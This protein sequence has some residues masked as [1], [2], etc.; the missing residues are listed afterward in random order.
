MHLVAGEGPRT[1]YLV[2]TTQEERSGRPP[3]VLQFRAAEHAV[4][5]TI[6]EFLPK[7]AV[8]LSQTVRLTTKSVQG[9]LGLISIQ[10]GE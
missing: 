3:R 2:T 7:D 6:V 10:S 8:D 5:Q 4:N 9:C 1:L